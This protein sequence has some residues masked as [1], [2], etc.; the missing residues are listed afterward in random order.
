MKKNGRPPLLV[1]VW[2]ELGSGLIAEGFLS[3]KVVCTDGV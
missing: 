2:A 1:R 3:D